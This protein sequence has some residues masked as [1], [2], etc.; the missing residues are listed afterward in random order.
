M[1]AGRT[2]RDKLAALDRNLKALFAQ[3][4]RETPPHLIQLPDQLESVERVG[5]A[6]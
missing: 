2:R 4:A 6:A 1:R 3:A 5:K